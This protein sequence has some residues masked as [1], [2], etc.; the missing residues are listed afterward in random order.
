MVINED[1][2]KSWKVD[3]IKVKWPMYEQ[4]MLSYWMAISFYSLTPLPS[5]FTDPPN[6]I[7]EGGMKNENKMRRFFATYDEVHREWLRS[8]NEG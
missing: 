6:F 2:G 4:S 1:A 7:H 8:S 3:G 5:E